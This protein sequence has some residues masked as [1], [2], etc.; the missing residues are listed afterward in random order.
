MSFVERSIIL[1]LFVGGST[2]G[3]STVYIHVIVAYLRQKQ[4]SIHGNECYNTSKYS[5]MIMPMQ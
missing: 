1:S 2:I 5:Y 3:G 4:F